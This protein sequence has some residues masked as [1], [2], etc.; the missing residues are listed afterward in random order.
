MQGFQSLPALQGAFFLLALPPS[1]LGLIFLLSFPCPLKVHKFLP[2]SGLRAS[3]SQ[4]L[5][6]LAHPNPWKFQPH[7]SRNPWLHLDACS[8]SLLHT[9]FP[10]AASWLETCHHRV[11]YKHP[12]VETMMWTSTDGLHESLPALVEP[13]IVEGCEGVDLSLQII[14]LVSTEEFL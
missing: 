10:K 6:G 5:S 4:P 3:F 13:L 7:N 8:E 2:F 9:L 14:G 11:V 12:S 1:Y